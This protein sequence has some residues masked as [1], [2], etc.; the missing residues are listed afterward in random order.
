MA[1]LKI[2]RE[3][4]QGFFHTQRDHDVLSLD[5]FATASRGSA[6]QLDEDG[7]AFLCGPVFN[8]DECGGALAHLFQRFFHLGVAHFDFVNLNLKILVIAEFEFRQDFEDGAELQGLAFLE[9]DLI[10]FGPHDRNKLFLVESFFEILG[11]ERLQHFALN[12]IREAAADYGDGSF[13]RTESGDASQTRD[14]ARYF[15]R[16]LLDVLGRNFQLNLAFTCG[17]SGF[18]VMGKLSER[19]GRPGLLISILSPVQYG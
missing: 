10:D 4:R 3:R 14:I 15:I 18:R 5:R 2:F 8:G 7:I 11:H 17:F 19:E 9:F 16:S 12:V 13:A 6:R 1:P